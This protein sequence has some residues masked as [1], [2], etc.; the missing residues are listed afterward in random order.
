MENILNRSVVALGY[1]FVFLFCLFFDQVSFEIL[2][3]IFSIIVLFEF[4]EITKL[5]KKTLIIGLLFYLILNFFI[6]L[7]TIVNNVFL[8]ISIIV[9]LFLMFS[10]FTNKSFK[11]SK[12]QNSFFL[13]SYLVLS[14]YFLFSIPTLSNSYNPISILF[15]LIIIWS[16]DSAG[17]F[18]G[19]KY[20]KRKLMESVSPKK[21]VLGFISGILSSIIVSI[22]FALIINFENIF[23][24]ILIGTSISFIGSVGD[25]IESKFKRQYAVK[26]S[27]KILKSHGGMF[28]RL[29]SLIFAGPFVYLIYNFNIINVS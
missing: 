12:V 7:N 6:G 27:G 26:D 25:L 24:L 29:D 2:G 10:L 21:T 8:T 3:L 20:G 17:Y 14:L 16:S 19:I 11:F 23:H 15:L 1:S 9:N 22:I 18:F 28:D 4:V 5:P 13:L